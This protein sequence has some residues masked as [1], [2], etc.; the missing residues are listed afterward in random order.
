[1]TLGAEVTYILTKNW[2]GIAKA[3]LLKLVKSK[4]QF[5]RSFD[6]DDLED[7]HSVAAFLN[8]VDR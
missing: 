4:W 8:I 2:V 6:A 5:S 3:A 1:M 7:Y